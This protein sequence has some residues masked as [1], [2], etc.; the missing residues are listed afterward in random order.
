MFLLNSSGGGVLKAS[1]P[2]SFLI[3]HFCLPKPITN[4]VC[5]VELFC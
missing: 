3:H 1:D 2:L 4:S 5:A